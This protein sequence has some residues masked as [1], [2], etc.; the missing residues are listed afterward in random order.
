MAGCLDSITHRGLGL[1]FGLHLSSPLKRWEQQPLWITALRSSSSWKRNES[2]SLFLFP[3]PL[4]LWLG[5]EHLGISSFPSL[6]PKVC[7]VTTSIMFA[8]SSY[9]L[10]T[11]WYSF[12][13]DIIRCIEHGI[14][15]A[16]LELS[17]L[18]KCRKQTKCDTGAVMKVEEE[19]SVGI[20]AGLGD[21]GGW[22][23]NV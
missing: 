14:F 18:N 10:K 15:L 21:K 23:T 8:P 1:Y 11:C 22:L 6:T 17:S 20:L 19:V 5:T 9:L 16:E 12:M 13:G 2:S 7:S 3:C 4:T